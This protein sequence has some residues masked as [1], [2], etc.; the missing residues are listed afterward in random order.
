MWQFPVNQDI[1]IILIIETQM[2]PVLVSCAVV[3]WR[4]DLL[5]PIDEV[6]RMTDGPCNNEMKIWFEIGKSQSLQ[7]VLGH[8]KGFCE[9][10]CVKLSGKSCKRCNA[11]WLPQRNNKTYGLKD[12][13]KL[14]S[15]YLSLIPTQFVAKNNHYYH[16]LAAAE[17]D[18]GWR[19]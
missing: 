12:H 6:S 1:S 13:A 15:V 3:T 14:K 18:V 16:P 9:R 11:F 10:S 7:D 5:S 2:V 17:D 4:S 19:L 8:H